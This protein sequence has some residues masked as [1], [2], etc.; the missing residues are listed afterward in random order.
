MR[1]RGSTKEATIALKGTPLRLCKGE[2]R[3]IPWAN[4]TTGVLLCSG[5]YGGKGGRENGKKGNRSRRHGRRP[6]E[7]F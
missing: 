4:R 7:V 1:G 3:F 5:A 6:D 2:S